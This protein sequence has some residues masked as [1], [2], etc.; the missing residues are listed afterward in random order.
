MAFVNHTVIFKYIHVVK[1]YLEQKNK[2]KLQSS[3]KSPL[4]ND[5]TQSKIYFLFQVVSKSESKSL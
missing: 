2:R 4:I 5:N 1:I 3:C